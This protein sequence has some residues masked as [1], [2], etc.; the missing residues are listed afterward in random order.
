MLSITGW[1]GRALSAESVGANSNGLLMHVPDI[2]L[3][4]DIE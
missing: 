1:W 4:V 3:E 2:L